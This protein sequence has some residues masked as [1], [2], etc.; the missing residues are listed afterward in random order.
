MNNIQYLFP[1]NTQDKFKLM[2]FVYENTS[3]FIMN[4]FGYVWENRGW[5]DKFPIQVYKTGD[6]IAGIHAFTVD[7]KGP[8]IIKTYY[9]V[10]GK[11]FRGCGIAKKLTMDILGEYKNTDKEYLVNSEESS[12]GVKFYKKLFNN[13]YKMEVNEFN[14]TD[15]I[16]RSP[17]KTFFKETQ[18]KDDKRN[19]NEL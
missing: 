8:G 12:D 11:P 18:I 3:S 9:I 17:I 7:A 13:N 15:Y 5:W 10:T 2:E 6:I 14:T 1:N 19:I 4:T 16:F